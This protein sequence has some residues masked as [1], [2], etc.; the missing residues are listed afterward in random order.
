MTTVISVS[1]ILPKSV[2]Y[3]IRLDILI[4]LCIGCYRLCFNCV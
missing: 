3:V 1:H 2:N 4:K